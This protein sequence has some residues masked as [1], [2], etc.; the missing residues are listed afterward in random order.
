MSEHCP[1]EFL[2]MG[3]SSYAISE[4]LFKQWQDETA[5]PFNSQFG[6]VY[7]SMPKCEFCKADLQIGEKIRIMGM[8]N[9]YE[10]FSCWKADVQKRK[11]E[12]LKLK[13]ERDRQREYWHT[14]PHPPKVYRMSSSFLRRFYYR[15]SMV[16]TCPKCRIPFHPC[17]MWTTEI[18]GGNSRIIH[19]DCK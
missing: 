7:G 9:R 18:I 5:K 2:V 12:E 16:L 8:S 6:I 3:V 19:A 4:P 15:K 17:D 11:I 10:H 13:E 14:H 1:A